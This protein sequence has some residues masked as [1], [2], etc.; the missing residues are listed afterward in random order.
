MRTSLRELSGPTVGSIPLA[1]DACVYPERR[2]V[3][4]PAGPLAKE[5]DW[6]TVLD[7]PAPPVKRVHVAGA[8]YQLV[9]VCKN[10]DCADNNLTLLYAPGAVYAR[11]MLRAKPVLLGG[12]PP[13]VADELGRLW[14]AEW[15]QGR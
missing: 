8:T 1:A 3:E 6:L 11:L 9:H 15:R 2:L 7:A 5:H 13:A 4:L 12:P 14:Q 10:H